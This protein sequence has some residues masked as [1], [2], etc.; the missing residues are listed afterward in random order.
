[1][2]DEPDLDERPG[3]RRHAEEAAADLD[4]LDHSAARRAGGDRHRR[5]A[6]AQRGPDDH[7]RVQGG[8]GHR[9]RQDV[10]PLQGRAD[11]TRHGGGALRGLQQGA[12]QG[13]DREARGGPHGRRRQVLGRR[14]PDLA[15]RR[16]GIEHAPLRQL[17]RLPGGQVE[18]QPDALLRARRTADHHRPAGPAVRAED[19]RRS[20]SL[21]VGTPIY[22][23]RLRSARSRATRSPPTGSRSKS[24]SSSMRPT[25]ST[26]RPRR[27]SGT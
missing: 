10:H 19:A 16:V 13:E 5:P 27:A 11:R 12:R 6:S 7:H 4:R 9:S 15:L 26:S 3:G 20:G 8:R 2:A 21:G 22:Y 1:M 17:H 14:A 24:R 18:R 23:R 25:T